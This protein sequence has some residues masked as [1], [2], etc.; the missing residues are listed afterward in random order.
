MLA[1]IMTELII[2]V[3][4]GLSCSLDT[5]DRSPQLM[6][7]IGQEGPRPFLGLLCPSLRTLE[8]VQHFV[9]RLGGLAQ[10]GVGAG[11][12]QPMATVALADAPGERGH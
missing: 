1:F 3:Q 9:E 11:R 6:G 7:R 10:F 12:R 8:L 4:Q 5:G 2:V